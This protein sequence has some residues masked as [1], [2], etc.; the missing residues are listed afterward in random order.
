[1]TLEPQVALGTSTVFAASLHMNMNSFSGIS[2][3]NGSIFQSAIL[4]G[5][6]VQRPERLH[7]PLWRTC[8]V[9]KIPFPKTPHGASVNFDSSLMTIAVEE[10]IY[11]YD[12]LDLSPILFCRGYISNVDALAFQPGNLKILVSSAQGDRG[13]AS[14]HHIEP[15]ILV[16][17]LMS[18]RTTL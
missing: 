5:L 13:R 6:A 9:C 14:F 10:D 7:E 11:I 15:T 1:M 3:H 4:R 18:S 16:S 12:T 17:D 8:Q 2:F